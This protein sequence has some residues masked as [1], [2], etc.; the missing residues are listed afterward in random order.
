[1]N[2]RNVIALSV[3]TVLGS[4]FT[5]AAQSPVER[6]NYLVNAVMGCDGCHTPRPN[7]V[8]D[9]S[10]KFSGGSQIFDAPAYTVRGSNI[11]PDSE[12]GIGSWSGPDIKRALT[13]GVRPSGVPLAPQMPFAFYKILTPGDLDAIVAYLRTVT[14]LRNEVTLPIYKA[15]AHAEPIPDAEKSIGEAVPSDPVRR[16]F[17]LATIAH[18]MECH[19]RRPD[20]T[21]DYKNW[22]GKGGAEFK[23]PYGTVIA[24]NISSHK[25][26]GVGAW[27]DAELKRVLTHGIGRDGRELKL[28]MARQSYFSKMADADLDAIVAWIR[29]IPPV[30]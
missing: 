26:K 11:T 13:D 16:G 21:Q 9:L 18:C 25:D 1:M 24:R 28:P 30:E 17:Y 29:S 2:R 8:F 14:P 4:C 6:G 20:L 5:A 23:G 12:T 22:W 10:K 15:V 3:M 19:S 7:G 27:S